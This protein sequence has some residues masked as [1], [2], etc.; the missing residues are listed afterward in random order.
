[1]ICLNLSL[2]IG[3]SEIRDFAKA[4]PQEIVILDFATANTRAFLAP[5][6]GGGSGFTDVPAYRLD[7]LADILLQYLGQ[8]LVNGTQLPTSNPTVQKVLATGRNVLL[9]IGN[10][11]LREK[12]DYFLPNIAHS[13]LART[14]NPELLFTDGSQKLKAYLTSHSNDITM[15]RLLASYVVC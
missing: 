15:V 10:D 11:Y 5:S 12:S 3:L 1:M 13:S 7:T 4:H 14:E 6:D 9:L 8:V 2:I